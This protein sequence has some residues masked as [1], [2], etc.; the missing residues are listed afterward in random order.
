MNK[1]YYLLFTIVLLSCKDKQKAITKDK[2]VKIKIERT[3]DEISDSISIFILNHPKMEID[4]FKA[5]NTSFIRYQLNT[6]AN[7]WIF[8]NGFH[9]NKKLKEKGLYL[10]GWS[11]G[12]WYKYDDSSGLVKELDFSMPNSIIDKNLKYHNLI[13]KQKLKCDSLLS[14]K[15]G[16]SFFNNHIKLKPE[17][18]YWYNSTNSGNLLEERKSIPNE[19]LFRYSIVFNDTLIMT[20]IKLTFKMK[21]SF[22]LSESKGVPEKDSLSFKIKYHE[23][24]NISR[25]YKYGLKYNNN[26]FSEYECLRLICSNDNKYYWI[27]SRVPETVYTDDINGT[28]LKGIGENLIINCETGEVLETEFR[29][30]SIIN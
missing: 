24:V 13:N 14:V 18:S 7:N 15:F 17:K 11:F 30:S 6:R 10:N 25:E 28:I 12:K 20:P 3:I 2:P 16:K 22:K 21:D 29:V 23:A 5:S 9:K 1:L 19:L 4:S 26:E 8:Q 27:I